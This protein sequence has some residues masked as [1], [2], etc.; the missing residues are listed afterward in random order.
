M[1][2]VAYVTI[3]H[4][5]AYH[6]LR[7]RSMPVCACVCV[8]VCVCDRPTNLLLDL[9]VEVDDEILYF[10]GKHVRWYVTV[11]PPASMNEQSAWHTGMD[12][13]L[14][15]TIA[16][17]RVCVWTYRTQRLAHARHYQL[18][19]RPHDAYAIARVVMHWEITYLGAVGAPPV[20]G[21]ESR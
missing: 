15:Y 5:T 4:Q 18:N 6:N 13:H 19:V 9:V 10:V 7:M 21:S 8:C 20:D 14:I 17:V 12:N 16:R 1:F 11:R 3:N 2:S